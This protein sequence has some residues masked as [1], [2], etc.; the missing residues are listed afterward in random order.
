MYLESLP[1]GKRKNYRSKRKKRPTSSDPLKKIRDTQSVGQKKTKNLPRILQCYNYKSAQYKWSQLFIDL[2]M[3]WPSR[4]GLQ[5]TQKAS[6]QMGETSST[7]VLYMTLSNLIKVPV[8]L[9]IWGMRSTHSV[10]LLSGPLLPGV[11]A[12][13]RGLAIGQIELICIQMLNRTTWNRIVLISKLGTYAKLN[14]LK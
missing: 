10:T 12:P 11:V 8:M 7:S 14:Y 2:K 6:L 1:G 3:L 5:N 4:L 13:N 9:M